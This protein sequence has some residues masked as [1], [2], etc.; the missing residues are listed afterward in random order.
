VHEPVLTVRGAEEGE[1]AQVRTL[2]ESVSPR[3]TS[4]R[5][6]SDL[7]REVDGGSGTW[8]VAE[9]AGELVGAAL[10]DFAGPR[11]PTVICV[12]VHPGAR[13]IGVGTALLEEFRR[14]VRDAGGDAVDAYALPGD[15]ETKNLY[16]RAGL[17]ARMIIA[18]G[19]A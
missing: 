1:E 10:V 9:S 4:L 7:A 6:A 16:E 18:S 11:R 15:R 3:A 14:I 5:G 19:P 2:L 17:T 12:A 13:G 8:L